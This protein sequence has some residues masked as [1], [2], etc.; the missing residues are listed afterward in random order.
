MSIDLQATEREMDPRAAL[1]QVGDFFDSLVLAHPRPYA[2]RAR[3][4]QVRVR[5]LLEALGDPHRGL[6]AIHIAGSKGKGSTALFLESIMR[7]AGTRT[8]T[9]TSP[10]LERWTERFRVDGREV[11][12][13]ALRSLISRMEPAVARLRH[14][15]PENP[16]TFFDV[17]TAA[18]LLLFREAEVDYAIVETGI[19]G[20]LDATRVV[21]A[22][23]CCITSIELEHTDKL[24]SS[25]ERIAHEKAGIIRPRVPLV[26]G[27]MPSPAAAVI[28]REARAAAAMVTQL[29]TDFTLH[30]E[31]E[32]AFTSRIRLRS[33]GL[34]IGTRIR[35][36]APHLGEC[37]ALAAMCASALELAPCHRLSAA[38]ATGLETAEL[39]GRIEILSQ[40]PLV[41]VDAA[42]TEASIS[43]LANVL[44]R[45][46]IA[47]LHAVVSL[48]GTKSPGDVLAPVLDLAARVTVTEADATRS[49]RAPR[50]AEAIRVRWPGLTVTTVADPIR[51]VQAARLGLRSEEALV[52]TGSVYM[53][54]IARAALGKLPN[55]PGFPVVGS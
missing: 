39:P 13:P 28:L 21:G 37:A 4:A 50:V 23:L 31:P 10:H 16:L 8:G 38:I 3:F 20:R 52:A 12:A 36:P 5:Q 7:A 27:R 53:A 2:E 41:V 40:R 15:F 35:S 6:R 24:G 48:S 11:E 17:A 30:T 47:R 54:G 46:S 14:R 26:L 32:N 29:D 33:G 45:M 19:G 22:V 9:F 43:A 1:H 25:L 42:H 49:I 51:A 18:A 34:E 44:R 55:D